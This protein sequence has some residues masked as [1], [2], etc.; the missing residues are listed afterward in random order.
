MTLREEACLS[1]VGVDG[2]HLSGSLSSLDD[3]ACLTIPNPIRQLLASGFRG[4]TKGALP[5]DT[6]APAGIPESNYCLQVSDLVAAK[7]LIPE[8]GAGLG[9]SEQGAPF[10]AVPEAAVDED[11]DTPT[12]EHQVR[13]AWQTALMQP[14]AET[15]PP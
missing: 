1:V 3:D 6:H 4:A 15:R 10:M 12:L 2:A 5:D 13:P 7:L 11:N 8:V 14:V 9:K